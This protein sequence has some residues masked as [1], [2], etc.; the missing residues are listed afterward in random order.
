MTILSH[1]KISLISGL[2]QEDWIPIF[3]STFKLLQYVVSIKVYEESVASNRHVWKR[4]YLRTP[5]KG[6]GEFT[7]RTIRLSFVW[8][9]NV[10]FVMLICSSIKNLSVTAADRIARQA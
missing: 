10:S 5:E 8:I 3:L 2:L 7:L 6:F 4:D 1:L 9:G